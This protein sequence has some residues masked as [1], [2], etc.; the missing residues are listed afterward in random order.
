[1]SALMELEVSYRKARQD[2]TFKAE[3]GRLLRT[4]AG[5]PTPLYYAERLTQKW[6]GADVF[7]KREDLAHTGAHKIN[8]CL[9]QGLLA[10]RTGKGRIIAETGAGQHGVAVAAVACLFGQACTIYMGSEDIKRQAPNV[11]RMRLHG[12]DVVPVESGSRTLKD[13]TNEAI[14]DWVTNVDT[15]H[16]II[17]STVGPHPYPLMVRDFQAIIG[18]ETK[19][20]MRRLRKGTPDV[21]VA[22]VGGGSNALGIFHPF[23]RDNNAKL[24]G[25]E[26]SG[27]GLATNL[28]AATL[29]KGR[30]GVLHGSFSYLLQ[31]RFG[32]VMTTHSVAAGLD[33]P[34]VGPE[35][36]YLKDSKR[37]KYVSVTDQEALAA[38]VELSE[39]EG[40]IPALE[41]SF[42]LAYAKKI[43]GRLKPASSLIINLSGRGD[44]DL[45]NEELVRFMAGRKRKLSSRRNSGLT[46]LAQ[47]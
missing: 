46:R 37:V 22:C 32:Q 11:V 29:Q 6:K 2:K 45:A 47:K 31:D 35:H 17:G 5:R 42:A 33:Y 24:I 27:L 10:K 3:L 25:V 13:A 15:T 41:S 26:S 12:A 36:S 40:I 4:F 19:Q 30:P 44:K 28:H 7:L 9:G 1:M 34:G 21:I 23:I 14:R 8:N 20:Q 39:T 43:A 16:Y 38:F 18:R